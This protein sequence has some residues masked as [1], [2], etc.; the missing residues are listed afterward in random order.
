MSLGY[1]DTPI[2]P[3]SKYHVHDGE[4][5]QPKV[6]TP[7]ENG[8]PPSDAIVL[9]DGS[10]LDGWRN[11]R[12]EAAQ[13]EI[14]DGA[15]AVVPGTGDHHT[16]QALGDGHLH[17]EFKSPVVVKGEGQG[18][19]NSGV[20]LMGL[21][22]IQVLDCYQ[23][24]TY[25]DGTTGAIYG[26]FPPLANACRKPGEWSTYDII[27]EGPK[28]SEEALVAPAR[29][30]VIL[31]GVLLHHAKELQGPTMHRELASYHHHAPELPLKLQDH[32]DLVEFRNIWF[33]PLGAYDQA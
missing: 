20:F 21:Y 12:G 2:I 4:R 27:F 31:N 28:F 5:P 15:L 30:T 25:P 19:G 29:V 26:Q 9:F 32:G 14:K 18:R 16:A 6:V 8:A 23:N 24:P 17:L 10:S 3:G 7:G 33:R 11:G 22:E 13:W 1:Q